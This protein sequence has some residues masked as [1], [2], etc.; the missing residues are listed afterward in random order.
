MQCCHAVSLVYD[1]VTRPLV[2]VCR[3]IFEDVPLAFKACSCT[4]MVNAT[5]LYLNFILHL[6]TRLARERTSTPYGF[7]SLCGMYGPIL[8]M[9]RNVI[10]AENFGP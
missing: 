2:K 4:L 8:E 9:K 1:D 7:D 5:I 6:K 10:L 3:P